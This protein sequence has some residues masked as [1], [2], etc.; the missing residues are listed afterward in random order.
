MN[1]HKET[2]TS[3]NQYL[4]NFASKSKLQ[5]L[6]I[7]NILYFVGFIYWKRRIILK[8][9]RIVTME[10]CEAMNTEE[11]NDSDNKPKLE[12]N[13]GGFDIDDGLLIVLEN[14]KK[15]VEVELN[16]VNDEPME[17]DKVSESPL[18]V[19]NNNVNQKNKPK[20]NLLSPESSGTKYERSANKRL[21]KENSRNGPS[22]N[23]ETSNLQLGLELTT[24]TFNLTS[25]PKNR[26]S[27]GRKANVD[28]SDPI[29]RLPFEFG[30]KRE[31]VYRTIG[32]TAANKSNRSGDVYYYS[33]S[34][35]KLRS[36]RE[37]QEH[38]D[39]IDNSSLTI[40]SFTFLK[41]PLGLNDRSKEI[42][43]DANTK[44]SKEDSFVS[45]SM[46]S[47]KTK[48]PLRQSHDHEFSD[49]ENNKSSSKMKILF[50]NVKGS[51]AKTKKEKETVN[52]SLSTPEYIDEDW[53]AI[54]SSVTSSPLKINDTEPKNSIINKRRLSV[55]DG[56]VIMQ[57]PCGLR[58]PN[59]DE[60]ATLMCAQCLVY[61]HPAC[62][63]LNPNLKI[64]GY[65]CINCRSS[66]NQKYKR[67][68]PSHTIIVGASEPEKLRIEPIRI[69]QVQQTTNSPNFFI[70][71]TPKFEESSHESID[72]NSTENNSK[73]NT[74]ICQG[75][76]YKTAMVDDSFQQQ[77]VYEMK[78]TR[79]PSLM[80][81]VVQEPKFLDENSE[82]NGT[83]TEP[84]H[85]MAS[86][87]SFNY[88]VNAMRH[89]FKHLK[90][91]ELLSA[92]R[93]CT[94]WN[95]IAMNRLLW[96]N[97]RLKNSMVYDWEKFVNTIDNLGTISL[98]TRRMLIPTKTD[99]FESFWLKFSASIKKAKKLRVIE[100]YRCPTHVVE[101]AIYALPQLAVLNSTSIKNPHLIKE[102]KNSVEF[103]ALSLKYLGQM[104]N[105]TE[106]RLKGLSGIKLTT[107]SSMENLVNLKTL[108]LT[109]IKQFPKDICK[110]LDSV[111][112]SLEFLEIG[113]CDC[114][115]HDFATS[116]R[117]FI[118]LR[119]LRLEN[120][121]GRWDTYAQSVFSAIRSLEKLN[122]LELINIEFSNCV[123]D[124]LEKCDGIRGLLIIPA[125]VSQSATTN[126]HLI[127]CLKKLSGTLTH[128][129]WGLTHELLRVTDLFIT[130]YQ[131][132]QH[133]IGY[134]L[135]LSHT[136]ETS[137]N[138]PILRTRK[139]RQKPGELIL[140]K[141]KE[142]DK[143]DNVDILSVPA[144]ETLLE[145]MMI[146]AKTKVIK[147]P[148]SAT[149]RVY[150]AEQFSDL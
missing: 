65:V 24:P 45:V 32:E 29:Y 58:C 146:G 135:E 145:N 125:Y 66:V 147:V 22:E 46:K 73:T 82:I 6:P 114:M 128:L 44:F 92:S 136:K 103:M 97:V 81:C 107:I 74:V 129:V 148:F 137:N 25:T 109:S 21:K 64:V 79:G 20:L 141:D 9:L 117:K 71:R 106:I 31:L 34:N 98:D 57:A 94:A 123:E 72:I 132:N 93:V 122:I 131:Q 87:Q 88:M 85:P 12:D 52:T 139:M 33:P 120:C 86:M 62:V 102:A 2:R 26:K 16:K 140:E 134:N 99:D 60:P 113:D 28:I 77:Y 115:P 124:E 40:E 51:R 37:I 75:A 38:L 80:T 118:N 3:Q 23:L 15:S 67:S 11:V 13:F 19:N 54:Q 78:Q 100:L 10:L 96:Q 5:N 111:S 116:L 49:D 39:T 108:S 69:R 53:Q 101:D 76:S 55:S 56:E 63:H 95:I 105:L 18:L 70:D 68:Q 48:T 61:Y 149:T 144:L 112:T 43:R 7:Y 110:S 47:K 127:D 133:T 14:K 142:K 4:F 8:I 50:K 42:I 121:C 126:C 90:T 59:S 35:K 89:V 130:Q 138:I 84:S 91:H 36:L 17:V 83:L 41:Q 143:Q 104:T 27:I 1:R 30:W 150:L 119:S